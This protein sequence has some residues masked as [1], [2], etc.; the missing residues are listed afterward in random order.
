MYNDP[1]G[2][3]AY[4]EYG[5]LK[6]GKGVL[7][8][9]NWKN[10]Q[11][12]ELENVSG[13]GIPIKLE[14]LDDVILD[15]LKVLKGKKDYAKCINILKLGIINE[16]IKMTDNNKKSN[17]VES[18]SFEKY[19]NISSIRRCTSIES[20]KNYRFDSFLDYHNRCEPYSQ[21][22]EKNKF[23]LDINFIEHKKDDIVINKGLAFIS[24][25]QI[26]II[27]NEENLNIIKIEDDEINEFKLINTNQNQNIINM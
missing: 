2:K 11:K 12:V 3:K 7:D 24:Y 26:P 13:K 6:N 22:N 18:F 19:H 25:E 15:Q 14:I 10:L 27:K 23:S 20:S 4:K 8:P 1:F 17:K 5:F 16:K 21:T 9:D